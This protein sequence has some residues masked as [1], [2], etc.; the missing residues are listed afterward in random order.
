[1]HALENSWWQFDENRTDI[2]RAVAIFRKTPKRASCNLNHRNF[3]RVSEPLKFRRD[4]YFRQIRQNVRSFCKTSVRQNVFRQNVRPPN[5]LQ[6]HPT[7]TKLM[8][9]WSPY[10]LKNRIGE[11]IVFFGDKPVSLTHSLESLGVQINENLSWEKHID[12]ICKKASAG[13]GAINPYVDI[14]TIQTIYNA[15]V[16]PYFNYYSTL[17]VKLW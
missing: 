2:E 14:N 5:K 7:K 17:W 9:I 15:L 8:F 16:Q 13:I 3:D 6:H 4:L 10:N 11:A 12:K 1:L